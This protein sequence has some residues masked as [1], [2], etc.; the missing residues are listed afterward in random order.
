MDYDTTISQPVR[1]PLLKLLVAGVILINL[2]AGGIVWISLQNSKERYEKEAAVNAQNISGV[3]NGNLSNIFEK[4][5][6][7][8]Q[9]VCDEAGRQLATGGIQK[10]AL[11]NFIVRLHARLPELIAFRA[12]DAAGD[13]IYGHKAKAATTTSL[14]HRDYFR[15]LRE[16]SD[17]GMVSSDPLIGGISG[18]W[19]IILARRINEPDGA[20][21]GLVYA[22]LGLDYL[23]QSFKDL[24]VG[25]NGSITLLDRGLSIM[26]RFPDPASI[27]SQFDR[28]VVFSALTDQIEKNHESATFRAISPLDGTE[29]IFSYRMLSH[30]LRYY[31]VTGL[32][33]VDYLS[34]WRSEVFKMS[35]F[36]AGFCICTL[37]IVWLLHRSW[38][39]IRKSEIAAERSL[40]ALNEELEKRVVERTRSAENAN[41]I[42][43][44]VI[45]CMSDWVW[46]IDSEKR[47]TY[48][49]PQVINSMGY[50]PDEMIGKSPFDFMADEAAQQIQTT[51]EKAFRQQ[52]RI[53]GLERHCIAR[54]GQAVL[55]ITNAVP[56]LDENG[57]LTGYRGVETNLTAHRNAENAVH[58]QREFLETLMETIPIPVFYKDIDGIYT[59]CNKA[60]EELYGL[61]REEIIGKT[62][63][64][65]SPKELADTYHQKDRELFDHPGQQ[66]YEWPVQRKN[67]EIRNT[68]VFKA[69]I[70]DK[71]DRVHGL[72]GVISDITERKQAEAERLQLEQQLQQA[73]K[74]ES[75]STM[76]GAI[77]HN[78]NNILAAVIGNLEIAV[79]EA[80]QGSELH[81][82]IG[83]ALKSSLRAVKL[84]QIMLTYLGCTDGKKSP[85]D[86]PGAIN[87][88]LAVVGPSIPTNIHLNT[89]IPSH[90]PTVIADREHFVQILTS[91]LFNAVEAIGKQEGEIILII[92]TLPQTIIQD[93]MF[94]PPGWQPNR[95]SYLCITIADTGPGI[96]PAHIVK[97]FDPFFSTR[98]LGR[99]LGLSMAAGLIR[100]MD[101]GISVVSK[102]G[103]GSSFRLFFPITEPNHE[104]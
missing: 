99:G 97:I 92:D 7:S 44:A 8:L 63:Y 84:T 38:I 56:I 10:D 33:P 76:A 58:Q 1:N 40:I 66:Q 69:T 51:F 15:F 53:R 77:A 3:L 25:T 34:G 17:S 2:L 101:G 22:G 78:F 64:D 88:A 14:A 93:E 71:D 31:I 103:W 39:K 24:K 26:A 102:P 83:E 28:K 68:S 90:G 100:S 54:N 60:F 46:E 47:Y 18:K 43:Q 75:L 98:F 73:Q 104:K 42:L 37:T 89:D 85:V 82:C 30:N 61:P 20:F 55:F 59:G 95:K 12:T 27:G 87:E 6:L 96:D 23:S 16:N 4:V 70:M 19:M 48:C 9:S 52:S 11:D 36:A 41:R 67:G 74:A 29:R 32:A 94:F 35:L 65:I 81:E 5:D 21:A 62:V 79:D 45:D 80:P 49:S 72:I 57:N 91:V 13:A 50:S 86:V